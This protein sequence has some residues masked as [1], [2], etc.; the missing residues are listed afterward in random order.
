LTHPNQAYAGPEY[1]LI[2][3]FNS[4]AIALLRSAKANAP[5]VG[6]PAA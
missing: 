5:Q 1:V 2:I 4:M 3:N 6:D